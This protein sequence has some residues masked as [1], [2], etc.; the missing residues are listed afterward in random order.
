MSLIADIQKDMEKGAV[1][2]IT[3]YRS[4]LLS[5]ARRLCENPADAEDL[6]SRTFAKVI[7]KIETHNEDCDFYAWMK[8]IM[9]NLH[10]DDLDHPVARGTEAVDDETLEQCAGADWSTDEQILK[11]SDSEAIR[12]AIAELDPKYK[13]AMLM[14]YYDEFTLKEIAN[15]L[16]LPMGT[17]SR[18]VQIAH[19]LL[20][21]KL[22]A[23]FGKAK[24]PL[25]VLLA[26][27]LGVGA[28]F[29][30]WQTSLLAPLLSQSGEAERGEAE[31][32][33]L[34][35]EA[36][37]TQV[38]PREKPTTTPVQ[39]KEAPKVTIIRKTASILATA[40]T[41][42]AL[43][44]ANA[45]PEV[46]GA[47]AEVPVYHLTPLGGGR[48]DGS[49]WGN[50]FSAE[51][52][53]EAL[54]TLP[55]P[56]VLRVLVGDY[57][58]SAELVVGAG[59]S[60]SIVGGFIGSG[61]TRGEGQTVIYRDAA[62]GD[63]RLVK[64]ESATASFGNIVFS[65]GCIKASAQHGQA[66]M[67]TSSAISF[68]DC[69]FAKN[70]CEVTSG[71]S[72]YGGAIYASGGSLNVTRCAFNSNQL[73][74]RAD[75]S[76]T[77]GGAIYT[78]GTAVILRDS[79][80][81]DNAVYSTYQGHN[82]GALSLNGAGDVL[83]ANCVFTANN[84]QANDYNIFKNNMGLGG[85]VYFNPGTSTRRLRIVDCVFDGSYTRANGG[86]GGVLYATGANQSTSLERVVVRNSGVPGTIKPTGSH[87]DIYLNAGTLAL[88]NVLLAANS[89]SNSVIVADG[90]LDMLNCTVVGTKNGCGIQ[91]KGGSAKVANTI[92]WDNANGGAFAKDGTLSFAYCD[93]Q[94]GA[95]LPGDGN[96]GDDP[97][98]GDAV[99]F[100]PQS[101]AGRYTGGW[102]S[103]GAWTVDEADSPSIDAGD[104]SAS[105]GGEPQPNRHRAN[106]GYD[107]G[108]A[109]A[110]KSNL[111][112]PAVPV[113]LA[114]YLY[115][116]TDAASDAVTVSGE[117]GLADGGSAALTLY[118]GDTDGG[119]DAAAWGGSEGLGTVADWTLV[120]CRLSGLAG[121]TYV[122]LKAD[123]GKSVAWSAAGVFTP[124]LPP[125]VGDVGISHV[126]R[127]TFCVTGRLTSDGGSAASVRVRYWTTDESA[128]TTVDYNL[129][130]PVAPGAVVEM[131]IAGLEAGADYHCVL[132]AVNI[133]GVSG[134]EPLEVRTMTTDPIVVYVT[135][136]G[137]G[138][139]DGSSWANAF[140]KIQEAIDVCCC[141]GDVIRLKA[142]TY[143]DFG[144]EGGEDRSQ[145]RVSG[146]P[147]LTIRGGYSGE[148][149]A[150]TGVSTLARDLDADQPEKRLVNV[151]DSTVSFENLVFTNGC[152][153][154][155]GQHGLGVRATSSAVSFTDC[156]FAKNGM[157]ATVSGVNYGGAIYA[158]GGSLSVAR[159]VFNANRVF[160]RADGSNAYGGAIYATGAAVDVRDST[161][162]DN[163]VYSTYEAHNGGALSLN[164]AGDALVSNCVFTANN[165][166]ANDYN[167]FKNNMGLGGSVYF[168]PGTSTRRLRI[169]DCVFDGSYTRANGGNGGVLYATGAN[170]STSLERVVVRNSGVPGTIGRTSSHGD[171]YLNA[172]TLALTN[173]LLV[174]N[175][176]SNS[177]I[178]AN[179]TL[180]AVNC[181]VVGTKNGCGVQT[182]G[183]AA[184]VLN[185]ILW[186]NVNGGAVSTGGTLSL[187]YCDSQDGADAENRV[188]SSDPKL[189]PADRSRAYHLRQSSP[190]VGIGD[191]S[192]WSADGLDLA[193]NLRLRN[194]KID[195]GCYAFDV[196]GFILMLK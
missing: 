155:S 78:T 180:D 169:V 44:A 188:I 19:R 134:G 154:V 147:G 98:F 174:A 43:G 79:T 136:E 89:G 84:T 149:D 3:E 132:E 108:T 28:L 85:S 167:I 117:F 49:D 80:F 141:A 83:V 8:T 144:Y 94:D 150:V 190:C 173:V 23:E 77:Y 29:G 166:Q 104:P 111:G 15:C 47:G 112:E 130:E 59:S 113:A 148:G 6:V 10:R 163:A 51:Q 179:G 48:Q 36:V 24:K 126:T 165:T 45:E 170:Q 96:I 175:T 106:I 178:V 138:I 152:C 73:F 82:G 185:S 14:R 56:S 97:L 137:A 75:G 95:D 41:S 5:D 87:G 57:P 2:L 125:T 187:A 26:A 120:S 124:A 109:V 168:N 12:K 101:K 181:T 40:A 1:R 20:A 184:T 103:G 191:P 194:G 151:E 71:G 189:Y 107:A 123:D 158:S 74:R 63:L 39:A 100:H 37:S 145:C 133:T 127:N 115:P 146:A 135:P 129:G 72:N 60:I 13:Q 7:N 50:A 42:L 38:Q 142:G 131:K 102:F 55:K 30:A 35:E 81:T 195:L 27:L 4:R 76:N 91:V 119:T 53:Q 21:G 33:P 140:A 139:R 68:A 22:R 31:S 25:A 90:T 114:A 161:F 34:Q 105:V 177:V 16:T 66:V 143:A 86:N 176:G 118:G 159:C 116:L 17:V 92:L 110:S 11:N 69:V 128:A 172:G 196:P 32:F 18:R 99:W 186:D 54:N 192:M 9:V 62:A 157:E 183:G 65:N 46:A 121:K 61:E 88:T 182:K 58:L 171:I 156:V 164:G 122:R 67:A 153:T 70:G 160:R 64:V 52:F 93:S 193:R 162:T